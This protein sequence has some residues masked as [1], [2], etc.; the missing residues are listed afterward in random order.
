M[1]F[2]GLDGLRE[3]PYSYWMDGAD[4]LNGSIWRGLLEML[5]SRLKSDGPGPQ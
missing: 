3:C 2:S 5:I 4:T 1:R